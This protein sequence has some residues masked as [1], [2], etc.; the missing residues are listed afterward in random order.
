M[1][2]INNVTVEGRLTSRLGEKDFGY[3]N[4]TAKMTIH[5]ANN[6]S[7]K[8]NNEWTD[9][10]SYFDVVIWGKLAEAI[11]PK[12]EKGVAVVVQGRL[13]Q[14]RWQDQNGQNKSRIY[15][16]AENIKVFAKN[17]PSQVQTVQNT[18]G[19]QV[20]NEES[21]EEGFEDIPF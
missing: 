18:F 9:E 6:R 2:N 12:I 10:P 17:V 16:N 21:F 15:I 3:I 19:G 14:D 11:K 7:V 1:T 20:Q 8:K 13:Q 5:L 4:G